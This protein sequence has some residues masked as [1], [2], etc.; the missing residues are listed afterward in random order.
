VDLRTLKTK[1]D[2]EQLIDQFG[3]RRRRCWPGVDAS[4]TTDLTAC[5]A[6][7]EPFAGSDDAWTL[8]PYFWVP[9]E[10]VAKIER[11]TR[12]PIRAWIDQGFITA[13][14]GNS[15]DLRSVMDRIREMTKTFDVVEVPF[16]RTN[17]RTQGSELLEEGIP[18]FEVPQ[19]FTEL[20]YPTKWLLGA[21]PDKRIRH[22]NNPVL[23][24][25]AAC[26]QLDYDHKDNCQPAKP[27]RGKSS[28]R[29]DGIQSVVTALNRGLSAQ[30]QTM[31]YTGLKSVAC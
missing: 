21:Y 20:G 14:P 15:I 18:T 3:L 16:D 26:L 6:V 25:M 9:E 10:Q 31:S 4:W 7:F 2:P 29:I 28:K 23:N 13:T 8:L 24:W 19:N 1:Y 30:P 11:V 12:M 27:A 5:V 17:F 22:G